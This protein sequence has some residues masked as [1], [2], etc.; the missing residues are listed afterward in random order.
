VTPH[1]LIAGL[2][3]EVGIVPASAEGIARALE[4]R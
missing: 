4:R 3:T 2:V 1:E